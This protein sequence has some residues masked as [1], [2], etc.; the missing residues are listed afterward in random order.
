MHAMRWDE[1]KAKEDHKN[2][3]AANE[4]GI[5]YLGPTPLSELQR[6]KVAPGSRR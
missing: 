2:R 4:S 6:Y 1:K 3:E 5:G